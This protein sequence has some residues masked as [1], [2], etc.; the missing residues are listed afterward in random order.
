MD[1]GLSEN[2]SPSRT[3]PA[4]LALARAQAARRRP[5]DLLEQWQRDGSVRPA[6]LDLRHMLRLD[7]LALAAAAEYEAVLLSP[8]APLGSS[9]VV[10]PTSQDRTLTTTRSTEVVSDPTNALALE[11]AGRLRADPSAWVRLCTSHQTL[12]TQQ[13]ASE[14]GRTRHFRMF[15]MVDAAFGLPDHTVEVEATDR[16]VGVML[17]VL[18]SASAE[19]G[20][21]LGRVSAL[22]QTASD[23]R[24]LG[25]RIASVIGTHDIEVE[26]GDLDSKYYEGVRVQL[27][28]EGPDGDRSMIGDLGLFDWVGQLLGDR[29]A[30]FIAS[31]LGLQLLPVLARPA[32]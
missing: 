31:G 23:R 4:L 14:P 21:H 26:L 27:H 12:R 28:I 20:L 25:A 22:V 1:L 30:R 6:D 19:L 16:Q 15:C 5:V 2:D 18:R 3:R 9:S 32:E 7:N 24:E 17:G 29:R 13:L 8:V 11:A 10:A